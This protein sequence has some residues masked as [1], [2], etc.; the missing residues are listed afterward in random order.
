MNG[1]I[2]KIARINLTHGTILDE[3]IPE[4][5]AKKFLGG[6]GLASK[7]LFEENK[8]GTDPLGSEN[9]LIFMSGLLTGTP[10]PSAS[11]YSVVTESPLT[12]ILFCIRHVRLI[13]RCPLQPLLNFSLTSAFDSNPPMESSKYSI[14]AGF[15]KHHIIKSNE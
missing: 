1:L 11:R 5:W 12:N 10:S 6:R 8:P 15:P 3:P 7:Y 9:R 14:S 4:E 2:G 13:L